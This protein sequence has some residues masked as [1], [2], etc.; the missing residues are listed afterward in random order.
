MKRFLIFL[1]LFSKNLLCS[2]ELV[3]LI[4]FSYDRPMQ[5]Y[6]FLESV[7]KYMTGLGEISIIYRTSDNTYDA[8]YTEVKNRFKQVR[9]FQ[10]GSL[11]KTDFKPLVLK[12]WETKQDY[13]VFSTDD[14]IVKSFVDLR[15]CARALKQTN[16]YGFFLRLG[17]NIKKCYFTG[18]KV[19]PLPNYKLVE[20]GSGAE[21]YI[22]KF[23]DAEGSDWRYPNNVDMT[24][25]SKNKIKEFF[26]NNSYDGPNRCEGSWARQADLSQQGLFFDKSKI[27]NIPLNLVNEVCPNAHMHS[28]TVVELL[29]FFNQ[30]LKI[31]INDLYELN[32]QA[33]HTHFQVKFIAR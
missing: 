3:D 30:G 20:L 6:A 19:S 12:A 14:I 18:D 16:A 23:S 26:V 25:Y 27:V 9:F 11:P 33:P 31:D 24:I 17:K 15:E 13:L 10:Q 28:Y 21:A 32:N 5:L 7:D 1:L 2:S 8:A 29:K 22:Y 4:V